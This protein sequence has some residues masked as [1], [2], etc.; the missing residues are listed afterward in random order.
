MQMKYITDQENGTRLFTDFLNETA[1]KLLKYK[2]SLGYH[3]HAYEI[4][5]MTPCGKRILDYLFDNTIENVHFTPDTFWIKAGGSDPEEYLKKLA[6]RTDIVHLKDYREE[7]SDPV[8]CE[9][10]AGIFDFNR[11]ISTSEASGATDVVIELDNAED[12]YQAL[13]NS[14]KHLRK[15]G[16]LSA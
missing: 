13:E 4:E 7:D 3:N 8:M 10:G 12:P 2:L 6:G 16:F 5:T 14:F 9:L 15:L 1:E 11:L